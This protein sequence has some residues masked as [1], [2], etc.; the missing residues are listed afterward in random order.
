MYLKDIIR[1]VYGNDF[2]KY[3]HPD[4][5]YVLPRIFLPELWLCTPQYSQKGD[6]HQSRDFLFQKKQDHESLHIQ[7]TLLFPFQDTEILP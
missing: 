6:L 2:W 7:S 5:F 3:G 4:I 1:G